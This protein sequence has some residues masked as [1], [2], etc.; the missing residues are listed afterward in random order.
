MVYQ[1]IF[2]GIYDIS[3]KKGDE[4][5][6]DLSEKSSGGEGEITSVAAL[7]LRQE[8]LFTSFTAA[9][10]AHGASPGS[11]SSA[12]VPLTSSNLSFVFPHN[13]KTD[14]IRCPFLRSGG[15]GEIRT[16]ETLLGF[17]RFP[18]VRPRPG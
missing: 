7:R 5:L 2:N 10:R 18:V 11:S 3:E 15:E 9:A 17:T 8:T 6:K 13:T 1:F 12:L 14:T 4:K 16:L